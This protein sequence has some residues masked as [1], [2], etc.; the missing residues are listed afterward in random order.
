MKQ[1]ISFQFET[2]EL[3]EFSMITPDKEVEAKTQYKLDINIEHR[4]NIEYNRIF[5][6]LS[7]DIIDENNDAK[8]SSFK[9]S[10]VYNIKDLNEFV[11]DNKL[12]LPD[13]MI[14]TLNS[15]SLSTCRGILFSS[16]KGTFLHNVI[17]PIIDPL[18]FNQ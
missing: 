11:N 7:I 3:L 14:T 1:N 16:L 4:F 2:I 5:V 13:E 17:L 18:N 15:I 12:S 6:I 9:I 10:C 8:L